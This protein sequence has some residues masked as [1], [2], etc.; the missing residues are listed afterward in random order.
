MIGSMLR[1]VARVHHHAGW[2]AAWQECENNVVL[3]HLD[4]DAPT[5]LVGCAGLGTHVRALAGWKAGWVGEWR[6]SSH[7]AHA[8]LRQWGCL[9][10]VHWHNTLAPS[11][12]LLFR[13][14]ACTLRS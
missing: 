12:G 10:P 13:R 2:K 4:N 14:T 9:S 3:K 11:C 5:L 6:P 8:V 7:T 1:D